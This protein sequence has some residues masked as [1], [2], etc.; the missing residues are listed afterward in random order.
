MDFLMDVIR[1][2]PVVLQPFNLLVA[3][4]ATIIGIIFGAIPGIGAPLAMAMFLPIAFGMDVIPCM[5]IMLALYCSALYGGSI[6]S[7]LINAPGTPANVATAFDGYPMAKQG[8]AATALNIAVSASLIGGTFS[9]L[10]FILFFKPMNSLFIAFGPS[11]VFLFVFISFVFLASLGKQQ[12]DKGAVATGIGLLLG[13]MGQDIISGTIRY[14]WG[15]IYL[16]DGLD[17]IAVLTGWFAVTEVMF[18]IGQA[19]GTIATDSVLKGKYLEGLKHCFKYYKTLIKASIIGVIVGVIPGIGGSIAN[20][21]AYEA[22]RK[23]SDHPELWGTGYPEGVVAPEASN[24]AVSA[25][26]LIPTLALGIPGS[27]PAAII[28]AVLLMLGYNPGPSLSAKNPILI[29]AMAA[30]LFVCNILFFIAGVSMTNIY[31]TVTQINI[32]ILIPLI[33]GISVL[34]GYLSRFRITDIFFAILLGVVAYGSRK[35]KYPVVPMVLGFLLA[36]ML[37]DNFFRSLMISHTGYG[38]FFQGWMNMIMIA[39]GL[40]IVLWEPLKRRFFRKAS[41]DSLTE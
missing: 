28:L 10:V 36:K 33:I 35:A 17:I 14:S 24:N 39:A 38:I 25:S 26:S 21:G 22:C 37:E 31:K 6:S 27:I 20:V 1:S 30:G 2:F 8:R 11:Q 15:L 18:L 3:A 19:E 12:W 5:M 34:G 16:E 23:S 4:I 32:R 41:K 40:L 7:I 13:L 29:P 9:V